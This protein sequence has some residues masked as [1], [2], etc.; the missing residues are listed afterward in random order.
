LKISGFV[1]HSAPLF[2]SRVESK[3]DGPVK[4][5]LVYLTPIGSAGRSC[6]VNYEVAI[7]ESVNEVRFGPEGTVIWRRKSAD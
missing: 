7:P 1:F 3:I 5:V 2:V 4:T 6:D